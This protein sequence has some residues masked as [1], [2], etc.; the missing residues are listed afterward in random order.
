MRRLLVIQH[1]ASL[2]RDSGVRLGFLSGGP[3]SLSTWLSVTAPRP[4][5][6]SSGRPTGAVL[7]HA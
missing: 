3:P 2:P 1:S 7:L 4:E 5:S 6:T